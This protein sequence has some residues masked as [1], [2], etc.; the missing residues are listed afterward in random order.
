MNELVLIC[1]DYQ[2]H[3]DHETKV[4]DVSTA[5][6]MLE[7][8]GLSLKVDPTR[9]IWEINST[10]SN[11]FFLKSKVGERREFGVNNGN[12]VTTYLIGVY[13]RT[14]TDHMQGMVNSAVYKEGRRHP[15]DFE[16]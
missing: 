2:S 14:N 1:K 10:K 15:S 6:G 7:K 13:D 11:P 3:P 9:E 5:I 4:L 16:D 8:D 12:M